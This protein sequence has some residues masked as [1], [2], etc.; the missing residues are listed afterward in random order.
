MDKHLDMS[1]E[2]I[3]GMQ[4]LGELMNETRQ[5]VILLSSLSEEY[6]LIVSILENAKDVPLLKRRR[7]CS[8]SMRGLRRR[9]PR[10]VRLRQTLDILKEA[11]VIFAKVAVHATSAV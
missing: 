5:L 6:E 2:L 4:I 11:K 9:R 3:V 8:W 1:D 10:N 7:S